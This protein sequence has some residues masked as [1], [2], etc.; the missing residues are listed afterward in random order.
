MRGRPLR[1][2]DGQ[3]VR[4]YVVLVDIEDRKRAE[5]TLRDSELNLRRM[6]ET[7]PAMLWSAKPDG[8]IDYC[9]TRFLRYTGFSAEE[10]MG[11]GWR[12]TIHPEDA[13]RVAPIWLSCVQTGTTYQVEVRTFH[14]ADRTYRLCLV[15]ALPLLDHEGRILKW[16]G[17][18][19][20]MDD[21]KR[22]QKELRNIQSELAHMTRVM[23]MGELTASIAHEIN[24][25]LAAAVASSDS[26]A[27]W[28]ANVPPNVDKARAAAD[29]V[30]QAVSQASAVIQR[31]RTM[32][33]KA[34]ASRTPLNINEIISEAL[35]LIQPEVSS[36][37]IS[38]RMQLSEGMPP[39]SVD[40][41]QIAQVVLNLAMNGIEAMTEPID[42][43]RALVIRST[44]AGDAEIQVSVADSGSGLDPNI[45]A[46]LFDPFFTTKAGGMGMGLSISKSIVEAHGGRLWAAANEPRGAVFHFALPTTTTD[47]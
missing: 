7:I 47:E 22:A 29:R 45:T 3:I 11:A 20:D 8:T 34:P 43:L 41:V 44:P 37:R 6:T 30:V 13:A 35:S 31:I 4:W 40:R 18:I 26:C 2:A 38:L 19:F 12:R 15:T 17:S 27:A 16:Y 24:Q 21:W 39:V 10:A 28:L 33:K 14:A 42:G 46:R 1:N 23:T 5:Q 25:P 36:K 9:N 32:F